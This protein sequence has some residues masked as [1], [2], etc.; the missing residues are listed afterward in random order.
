MRRSDHPRP[1]A[2]RAVRP[3]HGAGRR[4]RFA[5]ALA[6]RVVTGLLVATGLAVG[7]VGNPRS[8]TAGDD[9]ATRAWIEVSVFGPDARELEGVRVEIDRLPLRAVRPGWFRADL[10]VLGRGRADIPR[11]LTVSHPDYEPDHEPL[12]LPYRTD[13]TLTPGL[14]VAV[15]LNLDRRRPRPDLRVVNG[16]VLDGAGAPVAGASVVVLGDRPRS[17]ATTADGAYTLVVAGDRARLEVVATTPDRGTSAVVAVALD[18]ATTTLPPLVLDEGLTIAGT[19]GPAPD[20]RGAFV[21]ATPLVA[22]AADAPA[23]PEGLLADGAARRPARLSTP[24]G[25]DGAFRLRGAAEGL[26]R[27]ARAG[28]RRFAGAV[29]PDLEDAFATVVRVPGP[30]IAL[31]APARFLSVSVRTGAT[32]VADAA[33]A[34]AATRGRLVVRADALGRASAWVRG[35]RAIEV[36]VT[37]LGAST[38]TVRWAPGDA[39]ALDVDLAV[40]DPFDDPDVPPTAPTGPLLH[41]VGDDGLPIAADL[42]LLDEEGRAVPTRCAEVLSSDAWIE[43]DGRSSPR[44]PVR[45]LTP[46]PPTPVRLEVSGPDLE[47]RTLDVQFGATPVYV[48]VRA[49]VPDP[50]TVR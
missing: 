24:I 25:L 36:T 38:R 5:P 49:R 26:W 41:V 12:D 40:A 27:V 47:A 30:S 44:G 21:L 15:A 33:V 10:G 31:G 34:F 4:R 50:T 23:G 16:R 18:A 28:P 13:G 20:V 29:H 48:R 17:V 43:H 22:G 45:L 46:L 7:A 3:P 35:D 39:D 9:R 37:Y 42:R 1:L 8:A 19:V 32:P 2:G 11:V 14:R 6:A